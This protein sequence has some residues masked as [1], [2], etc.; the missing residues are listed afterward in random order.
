M[1]QRLSRDGGATWSA[2]SILI[3]EP[4]GGKLRPGMPVMSRMRDGRYL[5][6]FEIYGDDPQCPVSMK[7]G[8]WHHVARRPRHAARGTTLRP[9][10][11]D[12]RARHRVRHFMPERGRPQRRQCGDLAAGGAT[13][14]A[15]RLPPFVVRGVPVWPDEIGVVNGVPAVA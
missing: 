5:L 14:V 13:G 7:L 11:R 2:K 3:K 10:P 4:G 8:R 6:V 1:S 15:V 12:D 9:A